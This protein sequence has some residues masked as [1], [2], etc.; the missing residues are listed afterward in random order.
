MCIRDRYI[1]INASADFSVENYKNSLD[2]ADYIIAYA[3]TT[4][5][6]S[7]E[8]NDRSSID[9]PISQAHVQMI[10]DSYPEKTIVV[11]STVGPVSYTHLFARCNPKFFNHSVIIVWSGGCITHTGHY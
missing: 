2:A 4:T 6:D 9:L 1:T 3:G 7:K 5:A 8:S 11:M 10:C